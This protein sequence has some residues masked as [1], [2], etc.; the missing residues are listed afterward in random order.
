MTLTA[1]W[2]WPLYSFANPEF[3]SAEFGNPWND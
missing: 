2:G 1:D 3:S